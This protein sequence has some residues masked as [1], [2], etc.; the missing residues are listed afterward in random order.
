MTAKAKG[1]NTS[2]PEIGGGELSLLPIFSHIAEA[3]YPADRVRWRDSGWGA[4]RNAI[5]VT[6][7]DR[8]LFLSCDDADCRHPGTSSRMPQDLPFRA[9]VKSRCRVE[10]HCLV[11]R[12][13]TRRSSSKPGS[14][15]RSCSG[16][17]GDVET[18]ESE[19]SAEIDARRRLFRFEWDAGRIGHPVDRI[20][21]ADDTG[22]VNETD[23]SY[24]RLEKQADLLPLAPRL[25]QSQPLS[26]SDRVSS[27]VDAPRGVARSAAPGGRA[28]SRGYVAQATELALDGPAR[29]PALRAA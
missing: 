9:R 19:C 17:G 29:R 6:G 10:P 11:T 23:Q 8:L 27:R 20:E 22:G 28:G 3:A 13:T 25:R 1:S 21:E 14:C 4:G 26:R 18:I 5:V 2:P 7:S 12:R 24:G 16:A 15:A